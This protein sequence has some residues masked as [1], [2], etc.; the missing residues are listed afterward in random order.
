M[1]NPINKMGEV[2]KER[3][4]EQVYAN[5]NAAASAKIA[6]LALEKLRRACRIPAPSAFVCPDVIAPQDAFYEIASIIKQ[7][8]YTPNETVGITFTRNFAGTD[9]L[10]GLLDKHKIEYR[11]GDIGPDSRSADVVFNSPL[12]DTD[13][14]K[15]TSY[16]IPMKNYLLLIDSTQDG[17][18]TKFEAAV[19]E[20]EVAEVHREASQKGTKKKLWQR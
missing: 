14:K 7:S 3:G 6:A 15:K 18:A 16:H 4:P 19:A 9:T 12:P 1:T 11:Y 5:E 17:F 20:A 8:H 2:L 10:R 13:G